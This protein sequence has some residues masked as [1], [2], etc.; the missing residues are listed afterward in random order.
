MT[1]GVRISSV[2]LKSFKGFEKCRISL[3]DGT[4]ILTG[5]NNAGKSTAISALRLFA[6]AAPRGARRNPDTPVRF[7]GRTARGWLIPAVAYHEAGF[8][9]ENLRYDFR[10]E[11]SETVIRTSNGYVARFVWPE[12]EDEEYWADMSGYMVA[13]AV[14][15]GTAMTPK[16]ILATMMPKVAVVPSLT[17]LDETEQLVQNEA[18]SKGLT[19]RH[20]SRYF[21]NALSRLD[22]PEF[23]RFKEYVLSMTPEIGDLE[24]QSRH[25]G[26]KTFLD[27]FYSEGAAKKLREI[28]WAGDGL[29]IWIQAL[30]HMWSASGADVL[31]LDEPDV[32][33]HPDLQRR[34]AK[35]AFEFE[36]QQILA[37][38]SLEMIA[39]AEPGST[40][41]VDRSRR[42]A[43]RSKKVGALSQ[44]GRRL[45]SAYELGVARALRSRTVLFVEGQ[46]MKVL[47]ILARQLGLPATALQATYSVLELGGFSRRDRVTVFSET[48]EELGADVL[49]MV[50][51]D[52]D[53]KS[54]RQ[55]SSEVAMLN[56][57]AVEVFVWERRELENYLLYGEAFAKASG[58]SI[59]RCADVLSGILESLKDSTFDELNTQRM[60]E[61]VEG[62]GKFES[63]AFSLKS[64]GLYG[65]FNRTWASLGGPQKLV[66]AKRVISLF[67]REIVR[68]HG[69]SVNAQKLARSIPP[70]LIDPEVCEVL[71]RVEARVAE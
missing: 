61:D 69:K 26:G 15:G 54:E 34:L 22:R 10:N 27:L 63:K 16:Q 36:G 53:L 12:Q 70:E 42:T 59:G 57:D 50:I 17:P 20:S 56:R 41:W 60:Q 32:F 28:V 68:L 11:D 25:D 46:D 18:F 24:L 48:L 29:Q 19:G 62:I 38:H 64:S 23:E 30:Y 8:V 5:A 71:R 55:L 43:Q 39:E 37:T 2:E 66:D 58:L 1:A 51:L 65:E 21:R 4:N 7:R 44:I 14:D 45:G 40:V 6:A 9:L 49:S 67:N 13:E 33:L 3:K 31:L 35:T 52:S 47:S